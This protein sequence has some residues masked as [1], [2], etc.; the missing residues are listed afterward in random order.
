MNPWD[1]VTVTVNAEQ[2][3]LMH[4]FAK[5]EESR[6]ARQ[7]VRLQNKIDALYTVKYTASDFAYLIES[8]L[9]DISRY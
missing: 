5:K 6:I 3:A 2:A 9:D 1:T 8:K 7:L 4:K